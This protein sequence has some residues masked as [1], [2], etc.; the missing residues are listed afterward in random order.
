MQLTSTI[1]LAVAAEMFSFV[2]YTINFIQDFKG[3]NGAII[4]NTS[5]NLTSLINSVVC[6]ERNVSSYVYGRECVLKTS[7]DFSACEDETTFWETE[8]SKI[9]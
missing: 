2:L 6:S 9:I 3:N 4:V 5:L 7:S 8:T 1:Q